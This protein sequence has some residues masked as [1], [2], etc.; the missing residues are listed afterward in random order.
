[1]GWYTRT[2]K[3]ADVYMF[4]YQNG[5][6]MQDAATGKLVITKDALQ[7]HYQV[8]ADAVRN[9]KILTQAIY[10]MDGKIFDPARMVDSCFL[11]PLPSL[12]STVSLISSIESLP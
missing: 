5:G 10:G 8:H 12:A 6:E 9:D 11:V 4:Y 2:S 3:G 1:M 7:K